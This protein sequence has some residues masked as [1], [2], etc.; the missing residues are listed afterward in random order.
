VKCDKCERKFD[1]QRI[2][3]HSG[4]CKGKKI[5]EKEVKNEKKQDYNARKSLILEKKE[6]ISKETPLLKENKLNPLTL[7]R[8]Y[9]KLLKEKKKTEE[10]IGKRLITSSPKKKKGDSPMKNANYLMANSVIIQNFEENIEN[11]MKNCEFCGKSF[12]ESK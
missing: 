6:E 5:E 3:K 11:M 9:T 12:P 4:I 1:L 7:I 2:D 8:N 10:I